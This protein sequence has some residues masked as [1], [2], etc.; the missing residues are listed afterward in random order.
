MSHNHSLLTRI[1]LQNTL[2]FRLSSRMKSEQASCLL[3]LPYTNMVAS[4]MSLPHDCSDIRK[5]FLPVK[6]LTLVCRP[7]PETT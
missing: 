2:I 4:Y 1:V 6:T 3:E 5:R 7:V